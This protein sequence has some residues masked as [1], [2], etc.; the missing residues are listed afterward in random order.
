MISN[1]V[2]K[3]YETY[4]KYTIIN[5][6]IDPRDGLK[7]SQR[8][9]LY[10]AYKIARSRIKSARLVGEVLGNYWPHG[11][12][13]IYETI[14][15][16][17]KKGLIDGYGEWGDFNHDTQ[18]AAMRY[19]ELK[20]SDMALDLLFSQSGLKCIDYVPSYDGRLEVP[21]Y[22]PAKLP[23]ALLVGVYTIGIEDMPCISIPRYT[24]ESVEL[25]FN[26]AME[27]DKS[28]SKYLKYYTD[29]DCII[30]DNVIYPR[31]Q[32]ENKEVVI[33]ANTGKLN[34]SRIMDTLKAVKLDTI[35]LSGETTK[36]I[37]KS[38]SYSTKEIIDIVNKK[39]A[40]PIQWTL[41]GYGFNDNFDMNEFNPDISIDY[42]LGLFCKFR[43]ELDKKINKYEISILNEEIELYKLL[44]LYKNCNIFELQSN[45]KQVADMKVSSVTSLIKS[46]LKS[47]INELEEK[48]A[49][50]KE[51]KCQRKNK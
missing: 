43:N 12:Q 16:L 47:R 22:L 18:Q 2:I 33:K 8:M 46:D 30:K 41:A 24:R 44:D 21:A 31:I 14:A 9:V 38:N 28:P 3:R 34:Y 20:I 4:V 50:L 45:V 15:N 27:G 29:E 10:A 7:T 42:Y 5:K 13:S 25:A 19:T 6:G 39:L 35:N 11:D 48:K 36:I 49:K 23:I 51:E 40:N 32:I 26:K 1:E 17:V 37:V